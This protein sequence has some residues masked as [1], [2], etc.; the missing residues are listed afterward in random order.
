MSDG[1]ALKLFSGTS[2]REFTERVASYLGTEVSEALV[3]RFS[4]GEVHVEI[5]TSVR[6]SDVFVLQSLSDPVND[7]LVELLAMIDAVRRSSAASVT[8]VVPY[9]GYARQDR[10]PKPRTP[11][12]AKLVADMLETAG[13]SRV[14]AVDLHASQIQGFFT[15]PLEH[16]F[17]APVFQ[18]AIR[19]LDIAGEGLVIVSPDTGGVD[20]ARHYSSVLDAPLAI[21]DKRRSVPN[22][23]E[24]M[25]VIGE[26]EG[27]HVVIVD[28]MVDTAGTLSRAAEVLDDRGAEE[29]DAVATHPV[30]SGPAVERL[31]QSPLDTLL[32][33]DTIPLDG[34]AEQ[35]D[36][37]DVISVD[38]LVG[39]AIHRIHGGISVSSIFDT[40]PQ[41]SS[42]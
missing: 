34:R 31:D 39:E 10:Q 11:V 40:H 41:R 5:Q 15:R 21:L 2:H 6:D 22:Q 38:E 20:R 19:E 14:V 35:S 18:S 29:V 27:R 24:V 4:D 3:D 7:H 42:G 8:A 1:N 30:L 12:T 23:S 25:N 32:V 33:T 16:L 37:L 28:D 17:A 26:V 9:F 13:V 36:T